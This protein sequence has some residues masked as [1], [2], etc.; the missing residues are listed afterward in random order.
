MASGTRDQICS[1]IFAI[2]TLYWQVYK[3]NTV[4]GLAGGTRDA[5]ENQGSGADEINGVSDLRPVRV[6]LCKQS[7]KSVSSKGGSKHV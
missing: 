4:L 5:A 3:A 1:L 7:K 2:S 6:I